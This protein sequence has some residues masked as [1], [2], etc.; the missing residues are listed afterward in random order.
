MVSKFLFIL[1]CCLPLAQSLAQNQADALKARDEALHALKGFNP[2]DLLNGYTQSPKESALEPQEGGNAL[3]AQGQNALKDNKTANDVYNQADS[4]AKVNPNP[5]SIEM[6]YAETLLENPESVLDGACDEKINEC[7]GKI[8]CA[9]GECD[10]SQNDKSD[11]M[12]EGLSRLGALSGVAGDVSNNQVQS[13]NP[14]IFSGSV[15]ECK[16]YPLGFRDCCTDSGWGDWVKQCPADLQ[17]LQRAKYENR[18]VYLGSYKHHKL[19][20]RHYAFCI[21]PTKLASIVQIQGRGLQLGIP[22]GS[23]EYPNCRGLMPEELERINFAS[24]DLSSIQQE[25]VDRMALPNN[26][27]IDNLNQSHVEKLHQQGKSHD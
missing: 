21:F 5:N 7:P 26:A 10:T 15:T 14:A 1:L 24:L 4:R 13:G 27:A 12:A 22:F 3:S 18:V 23:A 6:Q 8:A 16:K 19:K 11:D 2:A 20:A 9:D 25:L 17:V